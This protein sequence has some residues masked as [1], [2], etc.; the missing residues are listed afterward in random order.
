MH[1]AAAMPTGRRGLAHCLTVVAI[2]CERRAQRL[3]VVAE[4]LE[5]VRTPS[6]L[7]LR[8][9]HLTVMSALDARPRGSSV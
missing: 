4:K 3:P 2:E 7:A 5:A 6:L 1:Y 9:H 8:S